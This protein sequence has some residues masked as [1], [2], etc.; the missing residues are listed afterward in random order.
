LANIG[1]VDKTASVLSTNKLWVLGSPKEKEIKATLKAR[2]DK[3]ES[4]ALLLFN[5]Y[6]VA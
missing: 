2:P 4:I 5:I 1:L 3:S 6:R